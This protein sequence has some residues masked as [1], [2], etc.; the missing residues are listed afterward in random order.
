MSCP[1]IDTLPS[2]S[3]VP[4]KKIRSAVVWCSRGGY[5]KNKDSPRAGVT[6]AVA[7]TIAIATPHP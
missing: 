7:P 2:G 5:A 3:A 6:V 4:M 1:L